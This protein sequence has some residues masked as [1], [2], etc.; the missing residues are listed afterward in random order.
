MSFADSLPDEYLALTLRSVV[1]ITG[2]PH[3]RDTPCP[4]STIVAAV[5]A[6]AEQVAQ[7]DAAHA[8]KDAEWLATQIA[9]ITTE[10]PDEEPNP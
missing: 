6:L 3:P 8:A 9:S 5:S 1:A 7:E 2:R 4:V 10:L